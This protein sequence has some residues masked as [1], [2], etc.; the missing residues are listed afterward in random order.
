[1]QS[2]VL[3]SKTNEF[4]F[5]FTTNTK[6]RAVRKIG[7]AGS[8]TH[9]GELIQ[10]KFGPDENDRA[11]VT[12]VCDLFTSKAKYYPKINGGRVSVMPLGKIKAR[13]SAELTLEAL[14]A[15]GNGYGGE[16]VIDSEI[17]EKLGLGSSTSDCIA[18]SRAVADA[19]GVTLRPEI[20]AKIVVQAETASDSIM[21][22]S[23]AVL[24]RHRQGN[25]LE[26]FGG[27]IPHLT[28]LGFNTDSEGVDT[29]AMPPAE[30]C[31][32]EIEEFKELRGLLRRAV[33]EQS[34]KLIGIVASNSAKINQRKLPKP[35]FNDLEI[36]VRK[37]GA[38]GLQVAH[39]GTVVGLIFDP[40]QND[41]NGKLNHGENLLSEIGIRQAWRF[42]VAHPFWEVKI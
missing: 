7:K 21:Y 40:R 29:L 6:G 3:R 30:Y 17:P 25:V 12:I 35:K 15:R 20:I 37:A 10:G 13:R 39:S 31:L 8:K 2:Q 32:D 11:L 14:N 42:D 19:F 18:A 24:F 28:I 27:K 22:G 36:I 4:V 16:I 23:E 34:P 9:H 33:V 26:N 1:M 5:P 41:L 38:T